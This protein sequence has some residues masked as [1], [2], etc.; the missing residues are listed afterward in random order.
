MTETKE[1]ETV[2]K[3]EGEYHSR[4]W[5]LKFIRVDIHCVYTLYCRGN[6][7]ISAATGLAKSI[8]QEY[9]ELLAKDYINELNIDKVLFDDKHETEMGSR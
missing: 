3:Y 2:G 8:S 6:N 7:R 5:A 4:K 1:I 9:A